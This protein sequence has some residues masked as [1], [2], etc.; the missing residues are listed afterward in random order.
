MS[1]EKEVRSVLGEAAVN[2]KK[3][4][5]LV[6][7][8]MMSPAAL[9]ILHRGLDKMQA[10]QVL[11][12]QEREAV[13]KIMQSM[14]YIVTGDDTVFQKA[15]QHTQKNRYQTEDTVEEGETE[16]LDEYGNYQVGIKGQ[17]GTTVKARSDKE[18]SQ[19]A[20]KNMGIADRHRKTMPHTVKKVGEETV[21]EES[22]AE[23]NLSSSYKA[24][25]AAMLKKTGK[26]LADMSDEDKKKFF[27]SVD[28][29]HTAKNEAYDTPAVKK[30][31]SQMTPAEK[32]KNDERRKA[33]NTFQKRKRDNEKAVKDM[34]T[35]APHMKNPALGE[36]VEQIDE[37]TAA[38]QAAKDAKTPG[39][40]KGMAPLKKDKPDL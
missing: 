24:K 18:A 31:V 17:G 27:N 25:F 8:G 20:F 34:K 29:A 22:P 38:Q 12:P 3:L 11:N 1:F 28:A 35:M 4:D 30:P 37:I 15:K 19:K 2:Y 36:E 23:D 9:P 40:T 33:Y 7:Q 5:Q 26:S 39:A 14:L 21:S 13:N 32:K 6:R 10:G 16:Q